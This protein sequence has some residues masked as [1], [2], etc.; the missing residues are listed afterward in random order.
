LPG[1][2]LSGIFHDSESTKDHVSGIGAA[3]GTKPG[4]P[5]NDA[6]HKEF[7]LDLVADTL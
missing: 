1:L 7:R 5:A 4:E 3:T 6:C 2:F